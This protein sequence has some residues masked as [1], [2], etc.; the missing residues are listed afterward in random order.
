MSKPSNINLLFSTTFIWIGLLSVIAFAVVWIF[1]TLIFADKRKQTEELKAVMS[2]LLSEKESLLTELHHRVKNNLHVVLS[3]IN[4]QAYY[5]SDDALAALKQSQHRIYTISL[6]YQ[7]YYLTSGQTDIEMSNYLQDLI[8]Y[9]KD[10]FSTNH[11][12]VEFHLQEVSLELSKAVSIGLIVNEVVTNA[13]KHAFPDCRKGRIRIDL[14]KKDTFNKLIIAD[15]GTGM[16][17]PSFEQKTTT[18]GMNLIL[19]LVEEVE[20]Q[21]EVSGE[22]GTV[23]ILTFP[24]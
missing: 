2:E 23:F 20:G 14:E 19:G 5:A 17:S 4:S 24:T 11:I 16:S 6:L 3:L 1:I 13:L 7:K 10:N 12:I 15:N 9:L 8:T 21:L 18:L 22:K